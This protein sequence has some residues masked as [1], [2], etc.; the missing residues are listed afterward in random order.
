M[1]QPFARIIA[2]RRVEKYKIGGL[3]QRL[4]HIM[5]GET[6]MGQAEGGSVIARDFDS[7][8]VKVEAEDGDSGL[9]E[10]QRVR[11]DAAAGVDDAL[12]AARLLRS[13]APDAWIGCLF[14][15]VT[16]E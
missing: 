12:S 3:R 16:R 11:A 13:I 9:R 4:S 6:R 10:R 5:G 2:P 7:Q 8:R 15:P 1:V 14:Q